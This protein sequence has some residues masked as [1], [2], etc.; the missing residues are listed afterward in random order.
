MPV[1][2]VRAQNIE[3][4]GL[5]TSGGLRYEKVILDDST[6]IG[7]DLSLPVFSFLLNG[8]YHLSSDVN[9]SLAGTR[10]LMNFENSLRVTF[11]SYGGGHPGWRGE[12]NFQNNGFDTIEIR[13]V[14][15]LGEDKESVYITGKGP[16]N[17]ARAF[18]HRPGYDSIRVI[19]PDNAW[20]MG[21]S[22]KSLGSDKS[23][24]SMARR[25]EN[26]GAEVHR[27]R[28]LLPP[29]SEVSFNLFSE[30]FTGTWQDGL[31]LMFRDRYIHDLYEFDNTLF[32]REDLEW[33]RKCYLAVLQFAWDQSFYD[34]FKATY[35]FGNQLKEWRSTFG[36]LDVYGIWPTWPRLGLDKRNQWDLYDDLP[37]GTEQLRN[38]AE[39]ARQEGTK[40]FIAYNPWDKSTRQE[41][42]YAG[43]SRLIR[44]TGADGVVLDTRGSS[45]DEIQEA[46]DSVRDGVVM[47]SEG[48][49]VVED[50][51][52]IV[53]GRVHNAIFK[54]PELNLNKIIKPE[55]AIFRVCDVGEAILH[56]EIAIAFFNGYGTELNLY[57]PGRYHNI[58]ND[59][60]YLAR[61]TMLLRQNNDAFLDSDWVPLIPDSK[62]KLHINKWTAGDKTIY[63]VLNMDHNG[64]NGPAITVDTDRGQH[65]VS[66][67]HHN[68]LN[69]IN[70]N[71]RKQVAVNTGSYPEKYVGTRKE[72]SVDCIAAFPIILES[73]ISNDTLYIYSDEPGGLKV[74]NCNPAYSKNPYE[75]EINDSVAIDITGVFPDYEGK[76]VIQ[77]FRDKLLADERIVEFRGGRPWLISKLKKTPAHTGRIPGDMVLVP[78]A[79]ISYNPSSND[80]FI[81]YPSRDGKMVEIDSFLI[82][83]YPVT[84]E[85]YYRFILESGYS[86]R[87]TVNYLKHWDNGIYQ[88]GKEKYPVVNISLEDARAYASWAGKRLPTELEWQLAA[89]GTDGRSWPWGNEFHGTKCNN[90]FNRSTPVDAFRKGQSPWGVMDMVGNVWQLTGDVYDNGSYYF[91]IIRGGSYYKPESSWWYIQG[92]PQ[93][94]DKT[95]MLLLVSPGFDR[96]STVGFRCVKDL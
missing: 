94:L 53:S 12:L 73:R 7:G 32:E 22:I 71:G 4:F 90:S 87:D 48:M 3:N 96:S 2:I 95:Q 35:T 5:S 23:V 1:L 31:K 25:G 50:M 15:P 8:K 49:A 66:L 30:V 64:F 91:V 70:N 9:A 82:D 37:G 81:P 60:K 93:P 76:I 84:N 61:T 47:Y 63:T 68:E 89:Q 40:F 58:E 52:G 13:N 14:L 17:L 45:S 20:E 27:Y 6:V 34:R 67:W 43:M 74:W 65:Y 36:H 59:Y 56:R 46:A 39:V 62:K 54:S 16:W 83:R 69:V 75:T 44:E 10:F 38:F 28:T 57:R 24:V 42:P 72:A 33:I 26:K 29:G 18:L 11:A 51:P 55:F 19:L 79:K 85:D 78:A 88:Q 77:L 80:D 86:P 21:L 41:D 92:G